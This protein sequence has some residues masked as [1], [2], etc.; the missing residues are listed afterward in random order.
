MNQK[1]GGSERGVRSNQDRE[2][3]E[4]IDSLRA[5]YREIYCLEDKI[6]SLEKKI[7]FDNSYFKGVDDIEN[8]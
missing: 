5:A 7:M 6:E 3:L 8:V 4:L 2:T 1:N